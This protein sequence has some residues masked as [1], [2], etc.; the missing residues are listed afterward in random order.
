MPNIRLLLDNNVPIHL[1]PLLHP[2][3]AVH[4]STIGWAALSNGDLI[5]A[6]EEAG[7]TA[8]VTCDR[9]IEHQQNLSARSLA[10]I[11]L[12]TTHWPTIRNNQALIIEAVEQIGSGGYVVVTLP[13]PIRRR[14][15]YRRPLDT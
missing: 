9:N 14:G 8:M 2:H 3:E 5:N 1:I 11:V 7:F 10:F 15:A 6:T 4:A 13:R 12:T